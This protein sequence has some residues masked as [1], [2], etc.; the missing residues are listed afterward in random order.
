MS[1]HKFQ[2]WFNDKLEVGP[3]PNA[4]MKDWNISKYAYIINVSDELYFGEYYGFSMRRHYF[5][6]PM[7]EQKRDMGINSIFGALCT[8]WEAEDRRDRV[9]LHCHSGSNRSWTVAAAY[10]YMRT[11]VHLDRPTRSGAYVNK[12]VSNCHRA[13]LPP[14][15]EM[16]AW[17]RYIGN[18][19]KEGM[20]PGIL[21][22]SK[23]ETLNNF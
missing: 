21:T 20:Q 22:M 15:A 12:L 11:G 7:S 10:Y 23:I 8:L 9:Y 1:N 17:L 18:A 6:Y 16:E 4:E 3:M 13:Y 5:W 2:V 14:Q 19:L